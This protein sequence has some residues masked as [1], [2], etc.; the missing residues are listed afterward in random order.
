MAPEMFQATVRN[1][2]PCDVWALGVVLTAMAYGHSPFEGCATRSRLVSAICEETSG[3]DVRDRTLVP[4]L[5]R[6]LERD[7]ARRIEMAELASKAQFSVKC[8][9]SWAEGRM[10]IPRGPDTVGARRTRRPRANPLI[11]WASCSRLPLPLDT[12]DLSPHRAS[13]DA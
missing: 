7:P 8:A 3:V 9:L 2:K 13:A 6:L 1:L 5:L 12:V 10:V 11:V 4:L